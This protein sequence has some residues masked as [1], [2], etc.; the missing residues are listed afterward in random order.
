MDLRGL[1]DRLSIFTHKRNLLWKPACGRSNWA[2]QK[3]ES[4][5]IAIGEGA[6][7]NQKIAVFGRLD[8]MNLGSCIAEWV[9][10]N[11]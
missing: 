11:G 4:G 6:T 1:P 9:K 2:E 10:Q 8:L 5:F 7:R 3:R